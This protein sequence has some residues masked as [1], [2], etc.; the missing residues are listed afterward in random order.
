[1]SFKSFALEANFYFLIFS[2][3]FIFTS[4]LRLKLLY[5][6]FFNV[7]GTAGLWSCVKPNTTQ[8]RPPT[9]WILVTLLLAFITI[10]ESEERNEVY[11][12]KDI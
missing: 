4:K 3:N 9:L 5:L 6:N 12:C 8:T 10:D 7:T 11:D 2:I 1:M